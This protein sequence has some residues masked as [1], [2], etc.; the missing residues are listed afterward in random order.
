MFSS[1]RR[2]AG[3]GMRAAGILAIS[4]AL[5]N[6]A[7]AQ[8]QSKALIPDTGMPVFRVDVVSRTIKVI[9]YHHRQ[10]A[11]ELALKGTASAPRATGSVRVDS[12]QGATKI[13]ARVEK[14]IPPQAQGSE[15][16]TYVLWAITPEGRPE[17]LGEVVI[18]GG[19][20][21]TLQAATELQSF[22]LIVTAEPY[23]AVTQPSDAIVMEAVVNPKT[24]GTIAPL[25]AKY[26]LWPKGMYTSRLPDA[27]RS[28]SLKTGKEA[29]PAL[30]QAKHALAIA[31]SMGA[32]RYAV[33]TVKKAEADLFN[34]EAYFN[35]KGELKRIQTLARNATQLAEDARLISVKRSEEE[36]LEAERKAA[37]DR[38]AAAQ[39][40]AE[41]E[42]RRRELADSER[43]LAEE[44]ERNARLQ[45]EQEVRERQRLEV[46]KS[47][48][49]ESRAASEAARQVAVAEQEQLKA[50][51]AAIA[52]EAEKARQLAAQAEQSRLAAEEA[53]KKALA[54]QARLESQ[55]Q[56]LRLEAEQARTA[57]ATAERAR[58]DAEAER[59]RMREQ[60]REQLNAVL[61]TKASAR[62]LIVNMSDVLFETAKYDLRPGAREK[63]AR[64]AGILATHPELRLEVEG[65]TDSTGSDAFNQTLSEQRAAAVKSYLASQGVKPESISSAGFGKSRP[66]ADNA[67]SAGRQQNRRVEIVVSG[68]SVQPTASS[69]VRQG[70]A[71]R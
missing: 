56:Q 13:E 44:R 59:T 68:E 51:K 54:E 22:G 7:A 70:S 8:E 65:H 14:L 6:P 53:S 35:N 21:A 11:T 31:K 57:A 27:H 10:G 9:N 19:G 45:A 46:E 47:A 62:G 24:T 55:Q 43:K 40:A 49:A 42:T 16:L 12:R 23:F 18:G 66:V 52:A 60:L 50:Q 5:V 61:A 4:A 37:A 64:V 36:R 30:T 71:D 33:D 58:Q 28:W 17:N 41:Q 20:D 34:A 32:D 67:T 2:S 3:A 29:P 69:A 48:L 38:L 15:Y 39:S 1:I 25:E 26:E 63:L